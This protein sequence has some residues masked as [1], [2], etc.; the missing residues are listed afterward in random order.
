MLY[1]DNWALIARSR[2][3]AGVQLSLVLSHI[4]ALGFTVNVQKSSLG[5]SLWFSV[6]GQEICYISSQSR[7][8]EPRVA[9][10]ILSLSCPVSVMMQTAFQ[11]GAMV[12]GHGG[13]YDHCGTFRAQALQLCV[14]GNPV[15]FAR[16]LDIGT[17]H[18][19]T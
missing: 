18:T 11:Y 14:R 5:Q 12:D 19:P 15:C 7:F 13:V 16:A 2:E 9:G 6:L 8:S 17:E 1:L 4:Q 3:E 10:Y